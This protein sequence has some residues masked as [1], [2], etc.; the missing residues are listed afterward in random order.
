MCKDDIRASHRIL[1]LFGFGQVKRPQRWRCCERFNPDQA[2]A[3]NFALD[4]RADQPA[5][6]A[7]CNI[8]CLVDQAAI[9]AAQ[10][11]KLPLIQR[12]ACCGITNCNSSLYWLA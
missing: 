3:C 1:H 6:T 10:L 11:I 9:I 12:V 8:G 5:R 2:L 7:Q 4:N